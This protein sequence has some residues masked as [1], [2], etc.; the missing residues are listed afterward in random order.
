MP[1]KWRCRSRQCSNN[2]LRAEKFHRP[3]GLA[4]GRLQ[5]GDRLAILGGGGAA[6]LIEVAAGFRVFGLV[7]QNADQTPVRRGPGLRHQLLELLAPRGDAAGAD[8][9]LLARIKLEFVRRDEQAPEIA[10]GRALR[11]TAGERKRRGEKQIFCGNVH[12]EIMSLKSV[13]I[14]TLCDSCLYFQKTK[15]VSNLQFSYL[16]RS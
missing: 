6:Q 2:S 16:S 13:D 12:R 10:F 8:G 11:A 5:R 3:A 15:K 14:V 7:G 4:A 9:K 1:P